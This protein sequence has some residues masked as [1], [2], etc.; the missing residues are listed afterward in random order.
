MRIVC[1][2]ERVL[3]FQRIDQEGENIFVK[4]LSADFDDLI[5]DHDRGMEQTLNDDGVLAHRA[6][7]RLF[8][9]GDVFAS[10]HVARVH[11]VKI[12]AGEC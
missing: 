2:E 11:E 5:E 7:L 4:D 10:A 8:V 6:I 3:L 1:A 12:E 9:V